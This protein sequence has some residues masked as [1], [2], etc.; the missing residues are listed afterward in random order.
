MNPIGVLEGRLTPENGRGMQFFPDKPGE[1]E[2][3]FFVANVIGLDCIE[4]LFETQ[5]DFHNPAHPIRNQSELRRTIDATGVRVSSVHGFFGWHKDYCYELSFLIR[6]ASKIGAKMILIPF[7]DNN[8]ID[9]AEKMRAAAEQLLPCMEVAAAS[10]VKL[11]IETELPAERIAEFADLLQAPEVVGVSYDIGNAYA[12]AYPV[13]EE[14][15]QLGN[16]IVGVHVKE[17]SRSQDG[18]PGSSVPL[19]SGYADFWSAFKALSAVGYK[20]PYILQGARQPGTPDKTV[21]AQYAQL[22]KHILEAS[23]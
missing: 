18:T 7:F 11:G 14:I 19:G 21:V 23:T 4:L 16:R 13:A 10:G 6:Q 9:T 3:E 22:V 12:C 17:R 8:I 5:Q 20:G 2:R 1:W 15:Q